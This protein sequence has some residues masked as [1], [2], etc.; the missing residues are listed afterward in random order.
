MGQQVNIRHSSRSDSWHTPE[1]IIEKAR[2]V[3]GTIDLDPASDER[4]NERIKAK[5]I[6]TREQDGLAASWP[7]GAIFLNP[8][9]GRIGNASTMG[10]FWKRLMDHRDAGL[11]THAIFMAF[12]IEAL[13]VTQGY[14]SR[15][16]GMFPLCVPRKRISFLG[17]DGEPGQAPSHANCIAYVPGSVDKTALFADTFEDLGVIMN[18][19]ANP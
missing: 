14:G 10:L 16:I 8:P 11:L 4:A 3:L 5:H 1:H 19:G 2:A 12:S 13:A 7:E 17:P 6:I 15:S 9:G 18:K